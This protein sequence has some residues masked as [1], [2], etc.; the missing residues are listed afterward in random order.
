MRRRLVI[1][2]LG[3][4][5][6]ALLSASVF[7]PSIWSANGRP[8]IVLPIGKDT[9]LFVGDIMYDRTIRAYADKNG[10]DY[11]F[12]CMKDVLHSYDLVVANLEGPITENSSLSLNT[13]IGEP[14][15]TRFTMPLRLA[16]LLSL[17]NIRAVSL[18]NNHINDF[19]SEGIDSTRAA[20][21]A[22]RVQFVGDP[23][24][25]GNTAVRLTGLHS[26][27]DLVAFNEFSPFGVKQAL[28]ETLAAIR[29]ENRSDVVIVFAHWG[30]EYEPVNDIQRGWAHAFVDAGADMVIGSH[31]HIVQ[32]HEM[33]NGAPIYYSLGNFIFDQYFKEEVKEGLGLAVTID[34]NTIATIEE[35]PNY[36]SNDR[37]TCFSPVE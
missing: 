16:N 15:N 21:S 20:L 17:N 25:P 19:G 10:D 2:F 35:V 13:K 26:H 34:G 18:A 8:L 3:A 23:R 14:D 7:M 11:I 27:V 31:P 9:I 28:E 37:R 32:D 33:Y 12:S 6:L 24:D 36:R 29:A 4:A 5:L 22:A 1:L 30:D